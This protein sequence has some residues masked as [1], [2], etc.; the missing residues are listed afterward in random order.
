MSPRFGD[1][2]QVVA[3]PSLLIATSLAARRAFRFKRAIRIGH[4]LQIHRSV[5]YKHPM[6][7]ENFDASSSCRASIPAYNNTNI[8]INISTNGFIAWLD[9][10]ELSFDWKRNNGR[11]ADGSSK[12]Q[13]LAANQCWI[14]CLQPKMPYLP[15][16]SRVVYGIAKSSQVECSD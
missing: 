14:S 8:M 3:M 12:K 2:E 16:N 9:R 7:C 11:H 5:R 13:S 10:R 15:V 1:E 6:H 4:A